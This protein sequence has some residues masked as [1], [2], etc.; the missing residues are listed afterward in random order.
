MRELLDLVIPLDVDRKVRSEVVGNSILIA[1]RVEHAR[2]AST[3]YFATGKVI[4]R[5]VL[6]T[7]LIEK[8]NLRL[9]L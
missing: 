7:V 4:G 2:H 8:L 6:Y 1:I 9:T 5:P 3:S